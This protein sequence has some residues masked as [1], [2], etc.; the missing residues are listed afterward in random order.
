MV[1]DT[2]DKLLL[3][4]P[5]IDKPIHVA[6]FTVVFLVLYRLFRKPADG[7]ARRIAAAFAVGILLALADEL[8]QQWEPTRHV[9]LADLGADIC[10]LMVGCALIARAK[11]RILLAAIALLGATGLTYE[12]YV[13]T[14]DYVWGMQYEARRDY[15]QA[16]RHYLKAFDSGVRT[17]GLFNGLGWVEIESGEGNP[18]KAVEY[19]KTALALRPGDADFLDTYGWAL[20]HAGQP[21]AALDYLLEAQKKKPRMYCIHYHLAQTYRRLGRADDARRHLHL[22]LERTPGGPD[23]QLAQQ[24]LAELD[25]DVP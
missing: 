18:L 16:R 8:I 23:A 1:G 13:R 14:R 3:K 12:S 2:L 21:Q 22:Q 6:G 24:A 15:A 11:W 5:G 17:A 9:E 20:L 7:R 10:G 19:A 4:A 25:E